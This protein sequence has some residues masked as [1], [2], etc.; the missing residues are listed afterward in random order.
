MATHTCQQDHLHGRV[1][2]LGLPGT[3]QAASKATHTRPPTC[4]GPHPDSTTRVL[5]SSLRLLIL[6]LSGGQP[7]SAPIAW[8]TLAATATLLPFAL[9]DLPSTL[10]PSSLLGWSID[11]VA[12]VPSSSRPTS[13]HDRS[14][15]HH[16]STTALLGSVR[17]PDFRFQLTHTRYPE[18]HSLSYSSDFNRLQ[19]PKPSLQKS[20]PHTSAQADFFYQHPYLLGLGEFYRLLIPTS[21]S[22]LF[23]DRHQESSSCYPPTRATTRVF[24]VATR[25]WILGKSTAKSNIKTIARG[26]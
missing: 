11:I 22:S 8:S 21:I 3:A 15:T 24:R 25:L 1:E 14:T 12:G 10:C 5:P 13:F 7:A 4:S 16:P 23:C 18:T 9:L 17:R 19:S 26:I 6:P 20:K 2:F